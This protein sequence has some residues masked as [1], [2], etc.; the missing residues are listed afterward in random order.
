MCQ[1][2][3]IR[4]AC[5]HSRKVLHQ[6]C[7]SAQRLSSTP[8]RLPPS[9][10][11]QGLQTVDISEQYEQCGRTVEGLTCLTH[12]ARNAIKMKIADVQRTMEDYQLR[13]TNIKD[14]LDHF[15]KPLPSKS[16]CRC[17]HSIACPGNEVMF[18]EFRKKF[19]L[20]SW[21]DW[22]ILTKK[23]T[24][25]MSELYGEYVTL[26]QV[27]DKPVNTDASNAAARESRAK[28]I[29]READNL[30][31]RFGNSCWVWKFDMTT[32]VD[33][34]ESDARWVSLQSMGWQPPPQEDTPMVV[35]LEEELSTR[36]TRGYYRRGGF[37][38]H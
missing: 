28:S 10:C 17:H 2:K 24:D 38:S 7:A 14:I 30:V 1:L 6:A 33:F 29:S 22:K 34:V 8:I 37:Q 9:H 27:I 4:F 5:G 20:T 3:E 36:Q 13:M 12:Q 35:I 18:E 16:E 26:L 19:L 23:I 32:I 21:N 25:E 15:E 11:L 31:E